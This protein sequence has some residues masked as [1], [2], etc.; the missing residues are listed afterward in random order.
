VL[1]LGIPGSPGI[2]EG[3]AQDT[4]IA[5]YNDIA[6]VEKLIESNKGQIAA[7]ILE[8]VMGNAGVILPDDGFLQQLRA[9]TQQHGIVLIFDEVITG[10][11]VALGG[12]QQ[13]YNITPDL[14]CLGKIIGGGLPVGAF[15]GKREIMQCLAPVGPVYQAGTLAGNPIAM[16]AGIAMLKKL[17][18]PGFYESLEEKS[19]Y[20]ETQLKERLARYAQHITINRVGSMS[21]MFFNSAPVKSYND[22]MTSDAKKYTRF[23]KGMLER[24]VYLAPSQYEASF[25]SAAHSQA[26]LQTYVDAVVEV[27]SEII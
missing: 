14:T 22:A 4:L 13:R 7:L 26:D 12:A 24:G 5:T 19:L 1:T 11:R 27:M 2:T 9:L 18:Q 25:V 16:A 23:F 17:S 15:G 20:I 6:S 3:V 21:C 10:F 8:P